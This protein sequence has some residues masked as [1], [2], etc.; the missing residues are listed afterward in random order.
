MPVNVDEEDAAHYNFYQPDVEGKSQIEFAMDK[1][2]RGSPGV[3]VMQRSV[4]GVIEGEI[5]TIQPKPGANVYL[6]IDARIQMIA[7][8][9]LRQPLLGR[10]AAVV[11]DPNNGDILA[12][13]S[14]P[15]FDPNVFIPS[16]SAANWSVLNKDPSV[17]LVDRAVSGF[18]PGST[19][20][21][22]TALAGLKQG[23]GRRPLQLPRLDHVRQSPVPL[24]DRGE[25][26]RPRRARPCRCDQGL[27]RLL[28][29]PIWQCRGN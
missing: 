11:I 10:A 5:R 13:A 29:L 27:L 25:A 15:S 12:M 9:A 22:V 21:I 16:V 6:T 8:Q 18:P 1:Y 20:K 7:E 17:P 19:F 4:R 2:L 14:I 28:L 23:H 26:R 3:R 24:L